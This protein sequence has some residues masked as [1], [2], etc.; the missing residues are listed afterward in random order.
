MLSPPQAVIDYILKKRD[1]RL[2][3][4]VGS[5]GAASPWV[6]PRLTPG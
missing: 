3:P 4:T 2:V 5:N 1:V 6:D